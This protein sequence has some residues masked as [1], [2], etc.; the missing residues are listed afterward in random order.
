ML[1]NARDYVFSLADDVDGLVRVLSTM[2]RVRGAAGLQP[3]D[4]PPSSH[5]PWRLS[6][7]LSLTHSS[8][9]VTRHHF[10]RLLATN[11]FMG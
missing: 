9:L 4:E 6:A 11:R 2:P 1:I 8:T 7:P 3:R 10:F 5:R